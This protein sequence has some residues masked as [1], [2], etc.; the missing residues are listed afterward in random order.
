[1][2]Q[3]TEL[4]CPHC[5]AP[6]NRSSEVIGKQRPP[7]PNDICMCAYC[8]NV[9]FVDNDMNLRKPTAEEEQQLANDPVVSGMRKTILD[10]LKSQ[11]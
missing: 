3:I 4:N 9:S 1:M 10:F 6:V 11:S 7:K 5:E 8:A 2:Y